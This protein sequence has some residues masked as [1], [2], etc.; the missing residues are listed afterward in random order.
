M[1]LQPRWYQ[2]EAVEAVY[3]FFQDNAHAAEQDLNP[4]ICMP[5]G[6]G[7]S[8]VITLLA[9]SAIR[10]YPTC[11]I[12][13]C[14][15]VKE[16]IVQNAEELVSY[17]PNAPVGI[18][19]AGLKRSEFG[20][21]ITFAGIGSISRHF[22]KLGKIDLLI[23]DEAHLLGDAANTMYGKLIA[24]LRSVNPYMR[25]IGL[26]ATPY[27]MGMGLLTDGGIFTHNIYDITQYEQF[28]RLV[29]EGYLAPLVTKNPVT[30]L[31]TSNVKLVHGE[32]NATQLQTAVDKTD[33]TRDAVD[34]LMYY[35]QE[36][37]AW[38]VFCSGVEHAEHTAECLRHYG[39]P[40]AA[41]HGELS[42]ADRDAAIRA[43]KSGELRALTNNNVLTTGFNYRPIDLIGMLRPTKSPGLWVQML[44][45]GTRP[46]IET[47]KLNCL[48][49]DYAG[50]TAALGPINDPR[51]PKTKQGGGG[52]APVWCCP[53]CGAYNHARAPYCEACGCEHRMDSKLTEQASYQA[54]MR[55][56]EDEIQTFRCNRVFYWPHTSKTTG[57]PSVKV[58][59]AC[60]THKFAE[61]IAFES[62]AARKRVL[63]W[64][65]ERSATEC[66]STCD[67][68]LDRMHDEL[69]KPTIV[70]VNLS[71]PHPRIV[72]VEF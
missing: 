15:H 30:K 40:A 47:E 46:S 28:N 60:G 57:N 23:I 71:G 3:R 48:V 9:S 31:D 63:D 8:L 14:T 20:Y 44:G 50:N 25:V 52:E 41:V 51:I 72:G 45:R 16:L 10:A 64:W 7:K 59:Y 27:R 54:V 2:Q 17:W 18:V 4:L 12:L 1:T 21:P 32:Y 66:P 68:A 6:T 49:L 55:T 5:T 38:L 29:R 11:R 26:T 22:T 69:K 58:D 33:V 70:R 39:V 67:E 53:Q 62:P 56:D 19:S 35:G 43:Y 34:E 65:G 37:R 24:Y 13:V 42:S 36:R 61:Y